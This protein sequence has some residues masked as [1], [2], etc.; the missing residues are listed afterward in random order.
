M[1]SINILIILL[2]LSPLILIIPIHNNNDRSKIR[3]CDLLCI[4]WKK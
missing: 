4:L 2:L 1:G 3:I